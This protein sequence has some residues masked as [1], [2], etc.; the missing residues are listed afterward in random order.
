MSSL[1]AAV[2]RATE[3][4]AKAFAESGVY[5]NGQTLNVDYLSYLSQHDVV[6]HKLPK[7]GAQAMPLG[8]GDLGAAVWCPGSLMLQIQKS[9]LWADPPTGNQPGAINKP[10]PA[11][12][13]QLSAGRVS[14]HNEHDLFEAPNRFE[15][16]L[17]LASGLITVDSDAQRGACQ[18]T[19]FA[20]ATAGV[21]V[22]HY[23]DQTLRAT[24]RQVRVAQWRNASLFALN[25]TVGTLQ[26][27]NDRRFAMIARIADQKST[28]RQL[29][30]RTAALEIEACRSANFTLYIA[31]ATSSRDGDPVRMAKSRIEA[32][33]AKGYA[34]LLR[35]HKQHW[36]LFWQ[37]SFLRMRG[38]E[39]DSTAAYLENLWYL[40]LYQLACC[41]RGF[42]AP[43]PQ[44]ALFLNSEDA[45]SGPALYQ[46]ADLRA[47]MAPLLAA[48]HLELTVPYVDTYFRLLPGLAARTGSDLWADGVR[49]PERFN[50]FGDEFPVASS[51]EPAPAAAGSGTPALTLDDVERTN[52]LKLGDGLQTALMVWEAW[53]YAPDPFFLQER[54]YPLLRSCVTFAL[55]QFR[56]EPS[57]FSAPRSRALLAMGLRALVWASEDMELD[58]EYHAEWKAGLEAVGKD[59]VCALEELEPFG[60]LNEENAT[61]RLRAWI[62][63]NSQQAQGFFVSEEGVPLLHR[64]GL[65]GVAISSVFLREEPLEPR[66]LN[67]FSTSTLDAR[68]FGGGVPSAL[69]LFP[70]L[71]VGWS[72]AF[73]LAAPGGFRIS[74]EAIAGQVRYVAIKSLM[75]GPLQIYNPWG[76]GVNAQ[77]LRDR[78]VLVD[79]RELVI[80]FN[81]ERGVTYT[82]EPGFAPLTRVLRM[83]LTGKRTQMPRLLEQNT[84]GLW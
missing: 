77:I 33:M 14:L 74:A 70:G 43:V 20:S 83:R 84:L 49:L 19:A 53:R 23:E 64:S 8:D 54:A 75:G 51:P 36:N 34:E 6:Y 22:V 42:D 4:N 29:D 45:R 41:S 48:N 28:A 62:L 9:D 12:W 31:V 26:S 3:P 78:T 46:G 80:P 10:I 32:A 82:I 56:R 35:D 40:H 68:S 17:N 59:L 71:P 38:P 79:S 11:I 15:Q 16:R 57:L 30:G 60:K 66:M 69:R 47:M 27:F 13:R 1:A 58:T 37:K 39:N 65:L 2:G 7:Q 24:T 5:F 76:L 21:L 55:E 52:R 50:R 72:G 44:G 25:E 73:T 18:V 61:A 63:T 67:S 81:T